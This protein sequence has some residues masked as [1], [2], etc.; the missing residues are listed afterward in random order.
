MSQVKEEKAPTT[1]KPESGQEEQ[2]LHLSR[3][4]TELDIAR[5][6]NGC[7]ALIAAIRCGLH[8]GAVLHIYPGIE[9]TMTLKLAAEFANRHGWKRRVR[10]KERMWLCP[11]CE[12][13]GQTEREQKD[14]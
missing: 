8:C 1:E 9:Q 14:G 13:K 2:Y 5:M 12:A 3:E 7:I 11:E 4:E 6:Y 10:Q